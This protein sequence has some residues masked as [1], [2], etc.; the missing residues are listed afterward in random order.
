MRWG[1]APFVFA[2][3]LAARYN[4]RSDWL[5]W[6][7]PAAVAMVIALLGGLGAA[8]LLLVPT[9]P[10]SAVAAGSLVSA[11]G[12]W[13][14]VPETGPAIL[15]GAG[16]TGLAGAS[17][18]TRVR[19]APTAGVGVAAVLGWA[20][21]SGAVGRPW[22]L[23]GGALCTGM[24]PWIAVQPLL[25]ASPLRQRPGLW[26]LGAHSVL[27]LVAARWI[28][29]VPDPGWIRVGLVAAGGLVVAVAFRCRA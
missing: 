5:G 17:A 3:L 1:G 6:S 24:A 16:I 9:V 8:R 21:L 23:V 13:A 10:W 12:V 29:V 18:A 15:A 28:A 14:A 19:W 22:A 25:P 11:A 27:V 7:G 4:G 20:A 2:V 26:L